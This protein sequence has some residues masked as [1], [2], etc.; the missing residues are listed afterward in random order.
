MKFTK[1]PQNQDEKWVTQ[2]LKDLFIRSKAGS[3]MG[4][5]VDRMAHS[6]LLLIEQLKR[7][8]TEDEMK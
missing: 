4:D 6:N 5:S 3:I 2:E 8:R 7:N 1:K